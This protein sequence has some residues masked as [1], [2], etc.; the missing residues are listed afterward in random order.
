MSQEE[1]AKDILN[2]YCGAHDDSIDDFVA[3]LMEWHKNWAN[4]PPDLGVHVE[5]EIQVEDVFGQS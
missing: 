2:N 4:R 5:D 1:E 3:Q